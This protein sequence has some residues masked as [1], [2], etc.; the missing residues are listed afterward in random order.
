ML[1]EFKTIKTSYPERWQKEIE[2][3]I[4]GRSSVGPFNQEDWVGRVCVELDEIID[5][6]ETVIY[7]NNIPRQCVIGYDSEGRATRN[8][9]VKYDDFKKLYEQNDGI[10]IKTAEELLNKTG[11]L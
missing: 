1:V 3:D 4:N 2:E 8:L 5:F 11:M 6:E 10:V 7:Q 9:L